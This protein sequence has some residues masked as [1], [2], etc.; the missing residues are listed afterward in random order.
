M[1]LGLLVAAGYLAGSLP[2]GVLLGRVVGRDPRAGGSGN[3]GASNVTR[4]LGKKWGAVTLV[5]DLLKG[6]VPTLI[7]THWFGLEAALWT[8]FAAVVGH[9]YPIWLKL[10]GGKGVATTFGVMLAILPAVALICALVWITIV[11]FTRIPA[12]GSLAA[13]ALFVALPRLEEQPFEIHVFT[14]ALFVLIIVR[15]AS[16][17]RTLKARWRTRNDRSTKRRPTK[18]G[19]PKGRGGKRR[20]R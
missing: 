18:S 14:L 10:K 15:H 1:Q 12:L 8:G 16:N 20:A 6:L 7:A 17:L 19:S 13:A 5:I 11:Y 9:C 3:I 4:T 2:T